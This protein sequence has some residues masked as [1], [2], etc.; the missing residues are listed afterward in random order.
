MKTKEKEKKKM[1]IKPADPVSLFPE[2]IIKTGKVELQ[3]QGGREPIKD[4]TELTE[5]TNE[6]YS[7]KNQELKAN[8]EKS[9]SFYERML[10]IKK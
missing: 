10:K 3:T 4:P 7:K 1:I 9:F 8:I 6:A 5:K 2:E